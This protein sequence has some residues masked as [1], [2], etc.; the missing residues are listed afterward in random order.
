MSNSLYSVNQEFTSKLSIPFSNFQEVD[1]YRNDFI[2]RFRISTEDRNLSSYWSPSYY[3]DPEFLYEKGTSQIAGKL[4]IEKSGS[5]SVDLTWD[6][7]IVCKR[8]K[9][10]EVGV[11]ETY[12]VWLRWAGQSF[13]NPGNWFYKERIS[14]TSSNILIPEYYPYPVTS[15]ATG[16]TVFTITT[17]LTIPINLEG[18][19]ITFID[20][21]GAGNENIIES[22]TIGNNS[23]ITLS[24]AFRHNGS[25]STPDNTTVFEIE[26]YQQPKQLFVEVYRP[27]RPVLRHEDS[28]FFDQR[29]VSATKEYGYVQF[30]E[31]VFLNSHGY[32][33]GAAVVYNSDNPLTGLTD[34]QVYY[35]RADF[36]NTIYLYPTKQDAEN[37]TNRIFFSAQ[38]GTGQILGSL[39]G[40]K[41]LVYEDSITTL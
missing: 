6:E 40:K 3:I 5:N 29:G 1:T 14:T 25:P 31:I 39:T 26:N 4:N 17:S 41:L 35:I 12:D 20:G 18:Q 8:N 38:I 24:N 11:I 9:E 36:F 27:G 2:V 22:N 13:S 30:G 32:I 15:T 10:I 16:G 33:T 7:V 23:T 34:G 21:K 19:K 37:N 28:L